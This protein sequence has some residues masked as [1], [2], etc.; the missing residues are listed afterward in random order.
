MFAYLFITGSF[1]SGAIISTLITGIFGGFVV[2][3]VAMF[4]FDSFKEIMGRFGG[5][6]NG[7]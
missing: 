3:F 1:V 6:N 7:E 4:G 5:E 2:A